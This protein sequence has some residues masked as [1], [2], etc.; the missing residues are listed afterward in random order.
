V[1][2]AVLVAKY[3]YPLPGD[4]RVEGV[5]VERPGLQR[6]FDLIPGRGRMAPIE[7]RARTAEGVAPV[8]FFEEFLGDVDVGLVRGAA[9]RNRVHLSTASWLTGLSP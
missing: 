8:L 6:P 9:A 3:F 1:D 4:L 7:V 5:E 2:R